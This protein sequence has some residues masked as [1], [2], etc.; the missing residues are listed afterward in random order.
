MGNLVTNILKMSGSVADVRAATTA[1]LSITNT[2][3][4][5]LDEASGERIRAG[6][7]LG[8]AVPEPVEISYT[9][10]RLNVEDVGL[11]VLSL[12]NGGTNFLREKQNK[13]VFLAAMPP[14]Y[15]ESAEAIV[16]KLGLE[17]MTGIDLINAAEQ[18]MPG[19]ILAGKKSI[20]AFQET[21]HFNWQ[22]WRAAHWGTRAYSNDA[23]FQVR[24]SGEVEIMFDT[25]NTVPVAWFTA[26]AAAHPNVMMEGAGYDEDNDY[27][28]HFVG[29]EPGEIL[30]EETDDADGVLRARET[31]HGPRDPHDD[32]LAGLDAEGGDPDHDGDH[33]DDSRDSYY[34]K[35]WDGNEWEADDEPETP[36]GP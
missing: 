26:V 32:D 19:C 6:F 27:A 29:D 35:V 13:D 10:D 22:E 4:V 31:V 21:G 17:G 16:K 7:T 20:I 18:A 33:D 2:R 15:S 3:G 9:H 8:F 30:I 25:V 12:A 36:S 23:Y 11:A 1:I 28:V 5:N 34:A 24:G 14:D